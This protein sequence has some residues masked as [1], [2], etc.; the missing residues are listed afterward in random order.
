ML[1][2]WEGKERFLGA[3][4]TN[5]RVCHLCYGSEA[6]FSFLTGRGGGGEGE[7]DVVAATFR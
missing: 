5:K 2:R 6:L 7:V 3:S 4:S 1:L